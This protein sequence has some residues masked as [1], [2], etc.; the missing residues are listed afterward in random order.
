MITLATDKQCAFIERLRAERGLPPLT[1]ID[2]QGMTVKHASAAIDALLKVR[3][4]EPVRYE[5]VERTQRDPITEPGMYRGADGEPVKVQRSRDS[6]RLY[7]KRLVRIG[8]ERLTE[9]DDV[10][11]FEFQYEKGLLY[12]LAPSDRMTL[13]EARA[14]GIR[15][16]VCC[17]CGAFLK[18]AT[19]VANGIGPICAG[20]I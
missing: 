16:G 4:A 12:S 13:D 15:Y 9:S 11:R 6:D 7:A 14:F 5:R 18:D 2:W 3:V 17:V 10:V 8:G 20:R 19:S 1:S